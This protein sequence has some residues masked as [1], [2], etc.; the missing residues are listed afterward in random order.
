M[1]NLKKFI[2]KEVQ[3]IHKIFLLEEERKQIE[4]ELVLL[5]GVDASIEEGT[6][7]DYFKYLVTGEISR[8]D[9]V[10]KVI[11]PHKQRREIYQHYLE[12]DKNKANEMVQQLQTAGKSPSED[13]LGIVT[14]I[15]DKDQMFFKRIGVLPYFE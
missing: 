7:V 15:S 5:E 1:E 6:P 9:V 3:R 8:D 4:K 10:D 13:V 12:T 2:Q 11:M 14:P